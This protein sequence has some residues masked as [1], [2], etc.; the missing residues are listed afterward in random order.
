MTARIP[1]E[2]GRLWQRL[3]AQSAHG[4]KTG[5]LQSIDT[6]R[7]QL[8][9]NGVQFLVHILANLSRKEKARKQQGKTAPANPFLPYEEDLYVTDISG[10]HLCL[11]NKFN[12]VAH[13]FLIVTRHFESQETWLTHSD[14]EAVARCLAEVDGL[15]F[16]NGGTIAGA[17]QPHKH[18]QIVPVAPT[19]NEANSETGSET[20]SAEGDEG[21]TSMMDII[22]A[23]DQFGVGSAIPS[24]ISNAMPN[25]IPNAIS[26]TIAEPFQDKIATSPKLPFRHAILHHQ[27]ISAQRSQPPSQ[28]HVSDS[29]PT[30]AQAYLSSYRA[31]L[32]AVGITTRNQW[33][34]LQTAPYNFLCT[35]QWMMVVPR[36]QEK[37]ADISVNS[38][39]FAGSLLVKNET[40]LAELKAT[41]PLTLLKIVGY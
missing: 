23:A 20:I 19:K 13:H 12:V 34:D 8:E 29:G 24:T 2:P 1:W 6:H 18:L 10:T 26:S 31:L 25:A 38:L 28:P 30:T 22:Q 39:G 7:V 36:S 16:F 14:F 41:G 37:H 11:L 3:K 15:V 17:S 4:L 21:G 27:N 35:R 33:Q 5:A 40:K 32:H 9:E